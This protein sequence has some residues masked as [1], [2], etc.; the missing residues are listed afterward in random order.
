MKRFLKIWLKTIGIFAAIFLSVFVLFKVILMLFT[1]LSPI[2][3]VIGGV[4]VMSFLAS[5]GKWKGDLKG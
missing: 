1:L 4:F 3:L 5:Y 2:V